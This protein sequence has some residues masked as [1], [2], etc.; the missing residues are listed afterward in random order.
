MSPDV[1]SRINE[2][3][4]ALWVGIHTAEQ[5]GK[6]AM[7]WFNQ[8]HN[9]T[10]G[11][12]GHHDWVSEADREVEAFIRETL[13]GRFPEH[14][15]LGEES[16]GTL[17]WPCWI[18]DPIDGTTNFL[19]G[20]ADFVVSIALVD[21]IGP[22]IGIIYYPAQHRLIYAMRGHGAFEVKPEGHE[23][24]K[25]RALANE[26]LVVGINLNYQPGIAQKYIADT[27]WLIEQGHQIRV[28]GSAAWSL[29]QV[30]C[31]ELDGCYLGNVNVWDVMAA[32]VICEEVG[33][34]V[35][36]ALIHKQCGPAWAWPVQSPLQS[37]AMCHLENEG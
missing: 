31:G 15:M 14:H 29:T 5:A 34:S 17:E 21:H 16:G 9:L 20:H 19:Y 13:L 11:S 10:I 1:E 2:L 12:K 26:Q 36:P 18:V 22:A 35:A 28:S 3:Q 24:L 30:A 25:P 27:K 4:D 33:L 7:T 8:R 23:A 6:K 32:Q 37:L